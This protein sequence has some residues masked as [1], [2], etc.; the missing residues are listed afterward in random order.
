MTTALYIIWGLVPLFFFL[1]ALWSFLEKTTGK[2]KHERPGD[3]FKQGLF[4]SFCVVL[5]ILIEAFVLKDLVEATV[6][7]L[8]PYGVFQIVL[9]PVILYLGAMLIGPS[10]PIQISKAPSSSKRK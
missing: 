6:Q 5:S 4:V 7:D 1:M 8:I 3:L 9:L 10:K 2:R